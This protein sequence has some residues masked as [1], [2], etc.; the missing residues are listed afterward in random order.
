MEVAASSRRT[1]L[2][3]ESDPIMRG[4]LEHERAAPCA[5][6]SYQNVNAGSKDNTPAGQPKILW[7]RPE[8]ASASPGVESYS[9]QRGE[10]TIARKG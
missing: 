9:Y 7:T 4:Q 3:L 8:A 1:G 5:T 10:R 6:D 2:M